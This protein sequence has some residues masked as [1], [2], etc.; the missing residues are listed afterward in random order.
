MKPSFLPVLKRIMGDSA[1]LSPIMQRTCDSGC[2][3]FT[4][5]LRN[6]GHRSVVPLR[7]ALDQIDHVLPCSVILS[8]PDEILLPGG[9][10]DAF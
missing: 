10:I 7:Q 3:R 2:F 8:L 4:I 5:G 9:K 1:V 6:V